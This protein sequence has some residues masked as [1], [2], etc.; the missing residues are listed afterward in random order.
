MNKGANISGF[1]L[2]LGDGVRPEL[3]FPEIL[4]QR[5]FSGGPEIFS[6]R[7]REFFSGLRFLKT[8]CVINIA[9]LELW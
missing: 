5:Y 3:R 4:V 6:R 1:V 8:I 7:R 9:L 2:S